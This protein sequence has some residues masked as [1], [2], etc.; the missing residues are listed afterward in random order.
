MLNAKVKIVHL[1]VRSIKKTVQISE[2]FPEPKPLGE[3]VKVESD[4]SNYAIKTAFKNVAGTDT[5][6]FPKKTDLANLIN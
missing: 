5:S 1:I 6:F 3:W 2:Y 4:L